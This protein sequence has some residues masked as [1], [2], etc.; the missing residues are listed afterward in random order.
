METY[1]RKLHLFS[2]AIPD[3]LQQMVCYTEYIFYLTVTLCKQGNEKMTEPHKKRHFTKLELVG[4]IGPSPVVTM[5]R[6]IL[7]TS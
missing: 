6:P 7:G 4:V 3:D 5:H 1:L 2:S